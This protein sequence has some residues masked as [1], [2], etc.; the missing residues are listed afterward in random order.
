MRAERLVFCDTLAANYP[1]VVDYFLRDGKDRLQAE[2]DN[3]TAVGR[4]GN[5]HQVI[6]HSGRRWTVLPVRTFAAN[7][8]SRA[9]PT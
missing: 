9:M 7:T 4:G 8:A 2:M 5:L 1:K 3:L 6:S